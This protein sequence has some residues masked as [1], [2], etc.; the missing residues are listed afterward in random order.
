MKA[1]VDHLNLLNERKTLW[2]SYYNNVPAPDSDVIIQHY[3]ILDKIILGT[4]PLSPQEFDELMDKSHKTAITYLTNLY[5]DNIESPAKLQAIF[6]DLSIQ[7]PDITERYR[8]INTKKWD[9]IY[10]ITYSLQVQTTTEKCKDTGA[11]IP[12]YEGFGIEALTLEGHYQIF[13]TMNELAHNEKKHIESVASLLKKFDKEPPKEVFHDAIPKSVL[14]DIYAHFHQYLNYESEEE[15]LIAINNMERIKYV[16]MYS[17]HLAYLFY[18]VLKTKK[19]KGRSTILFKLFGVKNKPR[20]SLSDKPIL[21]E[22][23]AFLEKYDANN[24]T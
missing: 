3:H 17:N 18:S 11:Y 2:F 15:F 16:E 14:K 5:Y 10:S 20:E 21:Q 22:I 9:F 23:D 12:F 13:R 19:I 6:D 24:Q 1:V 8:V 7:L 4:Q